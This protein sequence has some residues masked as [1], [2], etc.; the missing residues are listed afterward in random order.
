M[1]AIT[2]I[3]KSLGLSQAALGAALELSQSAISQFEKGTCEPTPD[4]ARR[5]ISL[6][7][8]HGLDVSFD[9]IYARQD[10]DCKESAT[11]DI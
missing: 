3:R 6:A 10:G 9:T 8:Q 2:S 11:A 5:L 1:N 7:Q 4:V